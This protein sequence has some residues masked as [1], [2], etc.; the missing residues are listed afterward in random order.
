MTRRARRQ[1]LHVARIRIGVLAALRDMA[2]PDT[3]PRLSPVDLG[4]R[5]ARR[6]YLR[7]KIRIGARRRAALADFGPLFDF[8]DE[9][10]RRLMT[11]EADRTVRPR[12]WTSIA[13]DFVDLDGRDRMLFFVT[14]DEV[15]LVDGW[16]PLPPREPAWGDREEQ[17]SREYS[18]DL[19]HAGRVR[20]GLA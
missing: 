2:K 15:A 12:R 3:S 7:T 17:M 9:R 13:L 1:A 11:T 6:A 14:S 8:I 16:L 18:R 19:D 5:T 10:C 20:R 4:S